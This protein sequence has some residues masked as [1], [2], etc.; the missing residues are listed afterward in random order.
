M[1]FMRQ[2]CATLSNT[3]AYSLL[4]A[5]FS[6]LRTLHPTLDQPF[7]H[8]SD[9]QRVNERR[10]RPNVICEFFASVP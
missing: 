1:S 5:N 9:S 2:W 7:R 4:E 3:T 6:F 10:Q 8:Q